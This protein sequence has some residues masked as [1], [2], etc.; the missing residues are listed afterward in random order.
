VKSWNFYICYDIY[1]ST[2]MFFL[3]LSE[4]MYGLEFLMSEVFLS[5][6]SDM[7]SLLCKPLVL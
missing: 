5:L 2:N 4:S 7:Y 3:V 1:P 6:L